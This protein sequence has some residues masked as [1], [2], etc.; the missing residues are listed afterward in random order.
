MD[1]FDEHALTDE[2]IMPME[3]ANTPGERTR[4]DV[5]KRLHAYEME[6][7]A[8]HNPS[9]M[10]RDCLSR[11]TEKNGVIHRNR[12]PEIAR[13]QFRDIFSRWK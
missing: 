4:R 2:E 5:E 6:Q 10:G 3:M 1:D 11:S 12:E 8:S 9:S 13:K 7:L